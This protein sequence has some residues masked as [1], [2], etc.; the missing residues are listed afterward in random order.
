MRSLT[1]PLVLLILW[2]GGSAC[3]PDTDGVAQV[4]APRFS[5]IAPEASGLT[6]NN[7][8]TEGP[9][10]NI[11]MYEYFYNGGGVAAADFNQDGWVDLYFTSNL[12]ENRLYLN[13]GDFT[14][15]DVTDPSQTAGRPGP[16]KTGV[17]V[18]DINADA[19]PDLYVSYSGMLPAEKRRNQLFI[20]G[21]SDDRGIPRFREAAAEYGLDLPAFSN[22]GYFFD[23]DGDDDL[24]LLLLNHNPKSL[25]VLN[26]EKTG[27]LLQTPDPE[28]GLRFYRNEE[29]TY[30]DVTEEAGINGSPLSYGLGLAL[31]DINGDGLIDFYLSNDYEVPDYL[32]INQG[33]GTFTDELS[34]RLGHT[35]HYSMGNDI[36]DVNNDG[37]PDIFTLDML[38]ADNRRRKLLMA[39]D[40]RSRHDL[41]RASGFPDQTMRNMLQLNRGDGSFAEIGQLAGV[42]ATDWSWSALFSDF[43]ND[44]WKDLHVTNGYLRDYTNMDFIKYMDDF[45]AAR[46]R[47]QKTDVL[48]MLKEMPAS[49]LNNFIFKNQHREGFENVTGQW[50]LDR[51]SNSNG[52]VAVDLDNDGDLDL[53]V[54][55]LNQPAFLYRNETTDGNYLQVALQGQAPNTQGIGAKVTIEVNDTVQVQEYFPNR[56]YLSSGPPLLHFGL[57]A[58]AQVQSL[59]VNWANGLVSTYEDVPANQ[60]LT[61]TQKSA[62]AAEASDLPDVAAYFTTTSSPVTYTDVGPGVRDFDRQALLPRNLS[63]TGP[64]LVTHDLNADGLDDLLIGGE[65]GRGVQ[66]YLQS[67]NGLREGSVSFR[68]PSNS[69][70]RI[71]DISVGDV[72]GDR[73]PD[74]Y[75]AH[76]GYQSGNEGNMNSDYVLINGGDGSFTLSQSFPAITSGTATVAISSQAKVNGYPII[77]LGGG[78]QSGAYPLAEASQFLVADASGAYQSVALA[79]DDPLATLGLV[80]DAVW[81]DLDGDNQEELIVV[82]EWMPVTVLTTDGERVRDVT[83]SYFEAS[84]RGWWYHL[85]VD[86]FD[87]DGRVDLLIGNE[88]LNNQYGATPDSPVMLYA[89]DQDNNGS[90][91]PIFSYYI[92][93]TRYPDLTRDELLSQLSGQRARYPNYASYAEVTADD[94]EAGFEKAGQR[95]S[96]ERLETSLFLRGEDGRFHLASLPVEAQYAPVYAACSL[97]ATGDGIP[98]IILGGNEVKARLRYGSSDANA[99]TLLRGNGDGTFEYVP[100]P[101]SGL[102]FSGSVRSLAIYN[103]MLLVGVQEG[104]V[105]AYTLATPTK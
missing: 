28:R 57:G 11:L 49:D 31:S 56:G 58:A 82:G 80:T 92:H 73:L 25:P 68:P 84:P 81:Q 45:V 44:G 79:E 98:D 20:N 22:Q 36:A 67:E 88:G 16:W 43:D 62:K 10:T 41:N 99:G 75:V 3:G 104:D 29:G 77:F 74:I 93:G 7:L 18:V 71:T 100:H 32:Y 96:A 24:D 53:V 91:D 34:E 37:L 9:N 69:L 26:A 63:S 59:R 78:V 105:S 1:Y 95:K 76:G 13:R 66:V 97:D 23:A 65:A 103:R 5:L 27:Q 83:A 35:S 52:A 8:L 48:E 60:R 14:F 2:L 85:L 55:N 46:G 4:A 40:N 19:L 6:F 102:H 94:L 70:L 87:G 30:R 72:N 38:P 51:P 42:S 47:L 17:A 50:G 61:V 101:L 21:G 39:D 89:A 64:V 54:N 86:D 33:D 12:G 15:T 90:I